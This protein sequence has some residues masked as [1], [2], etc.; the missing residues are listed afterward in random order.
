[1]ITT[2]KIPGT[3]KLIGNN[4]F[5]DTDMLSEIIIDTDDIT[6]PEGVLPWGGYEGKAL[7]IK[8]AKGYVFFKSNV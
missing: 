4:S 3:V 8:N 5:D 6:T 2:I 1:M 7:T